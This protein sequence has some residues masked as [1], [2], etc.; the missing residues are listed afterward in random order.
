MES[1]TPGN[2][3]F[4]LQDCNQPATES[5]KE[6]LAVINARGKWLHYNDVNSGMPSNR[7]NCMLYDKFEHVLWLG[8]DQSGLV[9]FNLTDNWENYHNN[10]SPM[11]GFKIYQLLQDSKGTIYTTTANGLVRVKKKTGA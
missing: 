8:T 3:Y 7:V 10:N 5:D 11:P 2:V 9:R 6:G 1:L 4:S